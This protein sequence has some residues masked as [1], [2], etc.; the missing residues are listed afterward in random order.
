[1]RGLLHRV[2]ASDA[3]VCVRHRAHAACWRVAGVRGVAWRPVY[4]AI[5]RT[6]RVG[7]STWRMPI[8]GQLWCRT[9][10]GLLRPG[11]EVEVVAPCRDLG[12]AGFEDAHHRQLDAAIADLEAI[13]SLGEHDV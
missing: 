12:I 8:F 1:M 6:Q 13:D 10:A 7:N 11:G 4:A 5:V 2:P 3:L 9:V